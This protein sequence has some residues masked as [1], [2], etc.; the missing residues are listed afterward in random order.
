MLLPVDI[1]TDDDMLLHKLHRFLDVMLPLS[2][3]RSGDIWSSK[4]DFENI[5]HVVRS[6]ATDNCSFGKDEWIIN[7]FN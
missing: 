6:Q 3:V 2:M 5:D 4:A 7:L 1:F